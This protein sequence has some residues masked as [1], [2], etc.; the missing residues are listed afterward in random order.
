MN[1]LQVYTLLHEACRMLDE[2]GDHATAAH[3]ALGMAMLNERY[4]V[5]EENAGNGDLS[6]DPSHL[7]ASRAEQD[8]SWA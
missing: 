7:S 6:A 3:V 8:S 5:G 1:A 2:E 4:H